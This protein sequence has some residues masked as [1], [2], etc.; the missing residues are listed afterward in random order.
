M[1]N[2]ILSVDDIKIYYVIVNNANVDY[3]QKGIMIC[4]L[5]LKMAAEIVG[6]Q[7]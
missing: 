2:Y 7:W 4:V 1:W 3:L 5:W 6:R